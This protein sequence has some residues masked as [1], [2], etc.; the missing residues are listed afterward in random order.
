VPPSQWLLKKRLVEAYYQI[1]E[2]GHKPVD[3]YLNVGFENLSH[4]SYTFKKEFGVA[5]SML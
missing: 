3:V 4:F 2:K 1:R 5:P